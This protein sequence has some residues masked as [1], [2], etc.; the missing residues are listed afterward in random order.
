MSRVQE[1]FSELC[2]EVE[3]ISR[4]CGRCAGDVKILVVSKTV[5]VEVMKELYAC[6][7]RE[8]GENREPELAMKKAAMPDDIVWHFIGPV[9][10]NKIR[11]VV[12]LADVIHSIESLAQLERFERIAGEEKRRLKVLLEVN[13]SGEESKGGMTPSKLPEIALAASKCVNLDFA[14]LM[15]MAPFEAD[16]AELEKIFS[17]LRI[18]KEDCENALGRKLPLLS[19][20]MSGDFPQAIA[21][22]STVVRVGSKIFEGVQK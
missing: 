10:S 13:V 5:P 14:G 22:G 12:K 17:T 21:C 11:K 8:F 16:D 3:D 7:V 20:G 1:K 4:S 6:G 2:R 15:T 18:L 9:Q 19:M